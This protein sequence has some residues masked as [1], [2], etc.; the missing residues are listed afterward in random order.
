MTRRRIALAAL[1]ALG[2]GA[3]LWYAR[4]PSSSAATEP[5]REPV[6]SAAERLTALENSLRAI[7][8]GVRDASPEWDPSYV[9]EQ[10]GSDPEALRKWVQLNTNWIPYRGSLR[11]PVGVLMDRQG[12]SLDRALLLASLL[13]KSGH[14]P[15]LARATLPLDRAI[16]LLP[17]LVARSTVTSRKAPPSGEPA[18]IGDVAS[19]YALDAAAIGRQLASYAEA[20]AKLSD[21]L[22]TRVSEQ[23]ARLLNVV[24]PPDRD[25]E[26][27]IRRDS[28]LAALQDHWWVQLQH[29]AVWT[30]L[31]VLDASASGAAALTPDETLL[32]ADVPPRLFHEVEISV[33]E[34]R[35]SGGNLT[36]RQTLA[37]LVRPSES[38]GQQIVL[39]FWPAALPNRSSS[40]DDSGRTFRKLASE[41]EEW[42]AGIVIGNDVVATATLAGSGTSDAS[43]PGLT[44]LG[45]AINRGLSQRNQSNSA[46]QDSLLTAVRIEYQ[47]NVPGRQSHT[48]RRTVFDLIGP[49]AR[50]NWPAGQMLVLSEKQRLTRALSLMMQTEI[51]PVIAHL[52]PEWM[53]YV[54]GSNLLANAGLLRAVLE[55]GFGSDQ[56]TTDSLLRQGQHG[57]SP[58]HTLAI[59]RQ[60]ALGS[61]GYIDRPVILTRHLFPDA[62][63]PNVRL[64]GATDIV[65]NEVGVS[66]AVS[67]GFAARL[68]QGVWDTNLEALLAGSP[69]SGNTALAYAESGNWQVVE[70][71][72]AERLPT[73]LPPD[74]QALIHQDLERGYTVVAPDA[75]VAVDGQ[76]FIG[77]WRVDPQ[78][79]D[80]LGIAGNGWGQA[81][82]YAMHVGAF[83]EMAK[84]FVFAY[85][86]CQFIPQE[87][88][89]LNVLREEF[90]PGF[91]PPG[92]NG[93]LTP[94][95][96]F[97]DVAV[98]NNRRCVIDAMLAGFLATAPLILRTLSY[99]IEAEVEIERKLLRDRPF[100]KMSPS[101]VPTGVG[102]RAQGYQAPTGRFRP[103]QGPSG[104]VPGGGRPGVDPYGKTSPG[105]PR[106]A[107]APPLPKTPLEANLQRAQQQYDAATKASL[108]ATQDFVRYKNLPLNPRAPWQRSI[109]DMLEKKADELGLREIEA[110]N[111][112]RVA[113]RGVE[114]ER[115]A[116]MQSRMTQGSAP[117]RAP[118]AG[119]ANPTVR[120][121]AAGNENPTV[122]APA[123]G[124]ENPTVRAPAAGNEN[125][126]VRVRDAQATQTQS[127]GALEVGSAGAA[128]SLTGPP[129]PPQ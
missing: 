34:E 20:S 19:W 79:G 124:N 39:Q 67:D 96:D 36:E 74:A 68:F 59:L 21:E 50:A 117:N 7:S 76:E 69:A 126:T 44:G 78:T 28:A 77:W 40:P 31:D 10:V 30:D 65:A 11:G 108:E 94:G 102:P 86:L 103:R 88:N 64:I 129:R 81:P 115:N 85:A 121:P 55:P 112:L 101:R 26:W 24:S 106:P 18:P 127:R 56:A 110:L 75:P 1:V 84:P 12:N 72:Q 52:A 95:K 38:V 119:N 48:I 98:E 118:A 16:Q 4:G 27:R 66:L 62:E 22:D 116:A 51:L 47:L 100:T 5:D 113:E 60:D 104:T 37:H 32:S 23:T 120:A 109:Q 41:Q 91:R 43:T 8:D 57:L 3:G 125:P 14:A 93:Q 17:D 63:S 83:V 128:S 6:L 42:N 15:R 87:A 54:G 90:W 29:G 123:A 107:G 71:S 73:V 105:L 82:D 9:A 25:A 70:A 97:E 49:V 33:V 92:W 111:E 80:A 35:L 99:R 45:G 114:L 58:L 61:T 122:R 46:E 53:T 89:A 13:T 2:A